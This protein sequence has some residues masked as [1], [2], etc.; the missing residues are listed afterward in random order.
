MGGDVVLLD[1]DLGAGKT[2]FTGGVAR[3][4]GLAQRMTSPTFNL[5]LEYPLENSPMVLRHFD[6]YRLEHAEQLDDLDYFGLIEQED[7]ISIVEWGSKFSERLPLDYLLVSIE[8]DAAKPNERILE[9]S[10]QGSRA[11][12]LLSQFVQKVVGSAELMRVARGSEAE[13]AEAEEAEAEA[14]EAEAAGEAAGVTEAA[15]AKAAEIAAAVTEAA[16]STRLTQG[17][18]HE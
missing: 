16:E 8:F 4:L 5:V 15:E 12:A 17:E 9:F 11:E 3:G 1:G 2:C 6:L 14:V 7:A 10:A 18:Q 13:E